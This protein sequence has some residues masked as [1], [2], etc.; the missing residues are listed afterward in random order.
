MAVGRRELLR[1]LGGLYAS[2]WL[3]GC[4]T[5]GEDAQEPLENL[6]P[7]AF[8]HGVAS[9]DPLPDAVMLWT[10]VTPMQGHSEAL[11]VRW[12]VASDL[13]LKEIV[14]EGTA[15]TD[16]ERDFTVKVDATGLEA[17]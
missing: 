6:G 4:T 13:A 3:P 14:A 17:D 8:F 16:A 15:D 2:L 10:R 1:N 5:E 11:Q 12:F 9:G 7:A